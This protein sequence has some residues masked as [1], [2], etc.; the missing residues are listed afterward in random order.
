M[1]KPMNKQTS[2]RPITRATFT[3]GSNQIW[4]VDRMAENDVV[5]DCDIITAGYDKKS[6]IICIFKHGQEIATF[7]NPLFCVERLVGRMVPCY[8]ATCQGIRGLLYLSSIDDHV[9][10]APVAG[11]RGQAMEPLRLK[12]LR[13]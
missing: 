3:V 1:D 5:Q 8:K 2:P 7:E 6:N 11:G 10:D 12:K 13:A 4:C 9:N